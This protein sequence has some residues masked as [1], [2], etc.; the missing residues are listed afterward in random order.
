VSDLTPLPNFTR[1]RNP[2][3]FG[4]GLTR[5]DPGVACNLTPHELLGEP[6]DDGLPF[7]AVAFRFGL[8][9]AQNECSA[10]CPLFK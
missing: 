5:G 2:T 9:A 3:A 8:V 6:G 10:G 4:T 1:S 7:T